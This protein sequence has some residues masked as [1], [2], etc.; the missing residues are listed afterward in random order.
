[1]GKK[2][3]RRHC[4]ICCNEN[5]GVDEAEGGGE[6]AA[7]RWG[8]QK[9]RQL[10][11]W[12]H[13]VCIVSFNAIMYCCI[14]KT[15]D[16]KHYKDLK[17]V[18]NGDKQKAQRHRRGVKNWGSFECVISELEVPVGFLVGGDGTK[19]EATCGCQLGELKGEREGHED[20][21]CILLD[22]DSLVLN[23]FIVI[24]SSHLWWDFVHEQECVCECA[25]NLKQHREHACERL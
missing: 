17:Q 8:R 14:I 9:T 11:M 1:M 3:K 21:I 16:L 22:N 19:E 13:I 4:R 2:G 10:C 5:T 25:G 23:D 12:L 20:S 24:P 6:G 7:D 15:I 18:C